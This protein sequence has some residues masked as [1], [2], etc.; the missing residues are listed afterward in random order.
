MSQRDRAELVRCGRSPSMLAGLVVRVVVLADRRGRRPNG[1]VA[2]A[3]VD[4]HHRDRRYAPA[5]LIEYLD[6][7]VR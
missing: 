1:H 2:D 3:A 6:A 7:G 5:G 4:R